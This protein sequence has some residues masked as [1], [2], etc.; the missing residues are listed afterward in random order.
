MTSGKPP[1]SIDTF[2][3]SVDAKRQE[4]EHGGAAGHRFGHSPHQ[5][6][7]LRAGQEPLS[8]PARRAI[9]A[10]ADVIENV[11]HVLDLVEDGRHRR[12]V[13]EAARV[14]AKARDDVGVLQQ[15]I[16]SARKRVAQQ[17][18]LA[19]AAGPGENHRGKG[20]AARPARP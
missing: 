20:A 1:R 4:L 13:E 11:R 6:R 18:S 14:G 10:G 12:V 5:R 8:H 15:V 9:D 17:G 2:G 7:L 3:C 19:G 16:G